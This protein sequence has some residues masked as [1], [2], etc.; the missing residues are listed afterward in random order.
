MR[1]LISTVWFLSMLVLCSCEDAT[2]PEAP[3]GDTQPPAVEIV[4]P[5]ADTLLDSE[6]PLAAAVCDESAIVRVSFFVDDI[7]IAEEVVYPFETIWYAGYWTPEETY[8]IVVEAEDEH[9]NIGV[10]Q[11]RVVLLASGTAFKPVVLGPDDMTTYQTVSDTTAVVTSWEPLPGARSYRFRYRTEGIA[12]L[13]YAYVTIEGESYTFETIGHLAPGTF[14]RIF[15]SVQGQWD[16][17]H[18]SSWSTERWFS[19]LPPG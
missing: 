3:D 1:F 16:S 12:E 2:T 17:D 10:S 15:W 7:A 14:F 18:G 19:F 11:P 9:G 8:T 5:D 4:S 6:I 13:D